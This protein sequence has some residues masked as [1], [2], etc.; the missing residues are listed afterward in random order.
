M[1]NR[2]AVSEIPTDP[3]VY[4]FYSQDR[5]VLYVGKALNLRSRLSSYFAAPETLAQR[6][7]LMVSTATSVDWTVVRTEEEALQLEYT[8]IKSY[9]PRFNVLFR[10][11][12]TYPYIAL[13]MAEQAP[14]A[15]ITRNPK[16]RGARYFGPFPKVWAVRESL[17]ELMKAVPLR[18]CKDAEYRKAMQTGKA[19]FNS[20]IAKCAGPCSQRISVEDYR[21]QVN[22]FIKLLSGGAAALIGKLR[23]EMAHAAEQQDYERAALARDRLQALDHVLTKSTVLLNHRTDSDFIGL[24]LDELSMAAQLYQVRGGLIQSANSWSGNI[25]LDDTDSV[26]R[27]LLVEIYQGRGSTIPTE[28]YVPVLPSER[29]QL[30][31]WLTSKS[32][33]KV[34]LK[35]ASRGEVKELAENL[36]QN[37]A[38]ELQ[39]FKLKRSSDYS[40]RAQALS[41]IQEALGMP[42]PPLR[43]ECIDISHLG[44]TGVVAS[45]VVFEDGLPKPSQY[46]SYNLPDAID[47]TEGVRQVVRRRL[48]RL[49][50]RSEELSAGE[51]TA[52]VQRFEYPPS[53]MLIDGGLPQ[54]NA[55]QGVFTEFEVTDITLAGLAKRLEELWLPGE[56]FPLILPRSSEGLYL[57]QRVRDEAHRF[58]LK[59]QT[60]KRK[61][62]LGSVLEEIP[63]LGP[64]RVQA[65]LARFGSAQRV[66]KA[67][68]ADISALSGF[69]ERLAQ[70][71]LQYL[72]DSENPSG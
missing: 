66:A 69:S 42:I 23:T 8:W 62:T 32:G 71:I 61:A 9:Q 68:V 24:A 39:R 53:L 33:K 7:R 13:T 41:E 46:R 57:L 27:K 4:R 25:E 15:I 45:L 12:K 14:R 49:R 31:E 21:K 38:I 40:A 35:V 16:I 29:E 55:A 65:L 20:Q 64:K 48:N 47:D 26:L 17:S 36:N 59:H 67:T 60:R 56:S 22:E 6:T 2:P 11:D 43:I 28:I 72:K 52:G 70:T 63:G 18:T 58:A 34:T 5:R 44:G 10:D 19:C 37:A 30:E 50:Q 51:D 1:L 54:V 3:G